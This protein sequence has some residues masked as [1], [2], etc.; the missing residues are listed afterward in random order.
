[1]S[2]KPFYHKKI[3]NLK[4]KKILGPAILNFDSLAYKTMV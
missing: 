4:E 1:M 2:Q 3:S